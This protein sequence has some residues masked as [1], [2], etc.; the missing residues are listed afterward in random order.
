MQYFDRRQN[1]QVSVALLINTA[2][3]F[4]GL[5]TDLLLREELEKLTLWNTVL[6]R[7]C[8]LIAPQSPRPTV[9]LLQWSLHCA[10]LGPAKTKNKLGK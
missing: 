1:V 3:C 9:Q 4:L 10:C 7:T 8:L 5:H 2:L 6:I